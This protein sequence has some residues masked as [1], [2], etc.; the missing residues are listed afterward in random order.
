VL[1]EATIL[2]KEPINSFTPKFNTDGSKL[3]HHPKGAVVKR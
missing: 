3:I 1:I 2:V